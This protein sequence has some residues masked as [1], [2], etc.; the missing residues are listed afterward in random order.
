MLCPD[1]LPHA[2]WVREG[3]DLFLVASAAAEACVRRYLPAAR[4]AIV[5][6][7]VRPAFYRPVPR[8]RGPL[9]SLQCQGARCVLLM[10]GGW[11]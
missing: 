10:G 1:A 5:P 3:I 7:P 4:T 2:A 9:A 8:A 11:G 6:P